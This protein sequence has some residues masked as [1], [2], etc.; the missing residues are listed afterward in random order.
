MRRWSYAVIIGVAL[1]GPPAAL[2]QTTDPEERR[3][4]TVTVNGDTGMWFVPTAE[5]LS[6]KMWSVSF[7]RTNIDYGQGFTDISTFPV[8][9]GVGLGGVAE[10]FGAWSIMT[11][12]DRDTR[13]LFFAST[14]DERDTGTGGG[15]VVDYPLVR[16]QW[17]S[18]LGDF[19]VGGKVRLISANDVSIAGRVL[20]KLPIGDNESGASSGEVDTAFDGIV[21][22]RKALAEFAG[23]AG[24]MIRGTPDGYSLTN[25]LR[26][27][28]GATF[29]Q[30]YSGGFRFTAELYGEKYFED[31]ITAPSGELGSDDSPV[32][33]TTFVKG[34]VV[35]LLGL[36]WQA[37]NGFFVGGAVNWNFS[38][39]SRD[40]ATPFLMPRFDSEPK[41]DK[42]FEIRIGFHPGA[43]RR[44][45][46]SPV[47]TPPAGG[48]PPGAQ[49]AKPATPPGG[50]TPPVAPPV[51]AP[52]ANRPPTVDATCEPCTVQ[53]GA[54]VVV[55]ANAKD[56]D[57]D[58]L[59]YAWSGTIGTFADAARSQ[60]LWTPPNV[61]GTYPLA[62]VVT[63]SR[64]LQ[65][66]DTV[67]VVVV[68]PA[69]P[70]TAPA[71]EF[72][73]E[74]V[75]F[76][77]DRHVLRQDSQ[78]AL[79]ELVDAMK[80]NPKLRLEIEGH[81]CDIGTTE[82]NL[83]LGERRAVSV[84]AYLIGVGVAADR[85]SLVSYGEERP[86]YS[87]DSEESRRLNRRAALV[88]RVVQV[89]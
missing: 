84:R 40:E 62:V 64:G 50:V 14:E 17:I 27:G 35:G 73:F 76:D 34:P 44:T 24:L 63:D 47:P 74:D 83:L 46:P 67:S 51:A 87:N 88:V 72:V 54:K 10:I 78:H 60:T 1:S 33:V 9:F 22:T 69:A 75:H 52:P 41:D 32:P 82:Y 70:A 20:L 65:A 37:P 57:N 16:S 31:S 45:A 81:T 79:A 2:A 61:A 58:P 19:W 55:T 68:V 13:P 89:P 26:W 66:R 36:T 38:M 21:S 39:N 6:A 42:S 5:V 7:Q 30:R 4:S 48:V 8:T 12:I 43:R 85:I 53:P 77:F 29:P 11:R 3:P 49:G 59:T 80:G 86:R 25:G 28:F 56:P 23:Y 15:I 18:E 71:K